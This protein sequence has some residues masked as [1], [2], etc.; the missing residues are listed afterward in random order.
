MSPEIL[1]FS[2]FRPGLQAFVLVPTG[3]SRPDSSGWTDP[4]TTFPVGL[5]QALDKSLEKAFL[6]TLF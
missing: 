4:A 2:A 1:F 6:F 3:T 5:S